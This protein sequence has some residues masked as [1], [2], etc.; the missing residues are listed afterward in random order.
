MIKLIFLPHAGGY[1]DLFAKF[2]PCLHPDISQALIE[3]PGHGR[4]YRE[5]L[6][7]SLDALRDFVFKD[8]QSH[9]QGDYAFFGHSMGGRIAYL[10]AHKIWE[11]GLRL[12]KSIIMSASPVMTARHRPPDEVDFRTVSGP[13][14][15]GSS[16]ASNTKELETLREMFYPIFRADLEAIHSYVHSPKRPLPIPFKVLYSLEDEFDE[17]TEEDYLQWEK[18][19]T[20]EIESLRFSGNH[21]F[22]FDHLE[23]ICG[24]INRGLTEG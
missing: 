15:S 19:T 10:L 14:N 1:A 3:Y 6:C 2:K 16:A 12:P 20:G 18:E 5:P 9:I 7:R 22:I 4:R 23:E 24:I 17:F 11:S 21:F 8:I 13:A